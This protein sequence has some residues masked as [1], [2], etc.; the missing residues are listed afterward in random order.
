MSL[1]LMDRTQLQYGYAWITSTVAARGWL[2]DVQE[3]ILVESRGD[4][5]SREQ[6]QE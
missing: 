2:A 1:S 4:K 3:R 5:L 6:Y